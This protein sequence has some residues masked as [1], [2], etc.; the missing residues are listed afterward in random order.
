MKLFVSGISG[1]LGLN[2][3]LVARERF[4]VSGCFLTHPIVLDGIRAVKLDVA[5]LSELEQFLLTCKPDIIMHTAGL[6]NVE[7]CED[8]PI[9]AHRLNVEATRNV[10]KI[11]NILRA[12]LVHISTDH[13][14]DGRTAWKTEGDI[15]A[16]L[17]TYAKTKWKAEEVVLEECPDALIIRTNFFGWGTP[18]RVSF[19]DWILRA[20][21]QGKEL[22]MFSDVYFTPILINDLIDVMTELL[23]RGATGIFHVGGSERLTKYDFA[24]Q[25]AEVFDHPRDAIRAIS[26]QNF[27]FRAKRPRDMS[28]SS[29]KAE[30]YLGIEM[31]A[32]KEGLHRLKKLEMEGRRAAV[33]KAM[34]KGL[35]SQPLE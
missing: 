13:V 22:T 31:P 26:V 4:Q 2:V 6:T 28:L 11:A 33:E 23:G 19:S 20:L 29:G 18:V 25:I 7:E 34:K 12:K 8:K 32:V 17:N 16:P 1:L 9:L 14:F 21:A 5:S 24:L 15:P 3:A 10:A 27:P 30:Q 35:S